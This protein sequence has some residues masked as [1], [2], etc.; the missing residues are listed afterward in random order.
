MFRA[1]SNTL[2]LR[3]W[4]RHVGEGT[5]CIICREGIEDLE[6]F[7]LKCQGLQQIRKKKR[8]LQMNENKDNQ[9][10]GVAEE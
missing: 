7:L 5:E 8:E 3:K 6:H 9:L 10:I 4:Y 1:R 2:K